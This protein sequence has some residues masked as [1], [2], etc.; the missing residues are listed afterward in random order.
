MFS[1]ISSNLYIEERMQNKHLNERKK[2]V[3]HILNLYGYLDI[4]RSPIN[5]MPRDVVF[6]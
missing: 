2:T 6:T 1:N 3:I 4:S 5:P